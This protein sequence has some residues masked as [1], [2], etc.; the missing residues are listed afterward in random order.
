MFTQTCPLEES[1]QIFCINSAST[2]PHLSP[3]HRTIRTL[4]FHI[5]IENPVAMLVSRY[6]GLSVWFPDVIKH[7]QADEYASR[8][9][10][11]NNEHIEDFTFNFTLENQIH[12]NSV[13]LNDR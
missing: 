8:V 7:L 10:I 9:K 11:H 2:I 4:L 1:V 13:F 6:Y 3:F 12:K 5:L